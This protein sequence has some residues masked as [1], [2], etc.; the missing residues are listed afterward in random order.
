MI[1]ARPMLLAAILAIATD[2][3]VAEVLPVKPKA[4]ALSPEAVSAK[5]LE[6]DKS[7]LECEQ[8]WDR[9]THM[10]KQDWART[11]RR[12]QDRI[13]RLQFK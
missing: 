7:I 11:C 6:R 5:K 1:V 13:E 9:G 8:L 10:T 3:A 2:V 4:P 12:V